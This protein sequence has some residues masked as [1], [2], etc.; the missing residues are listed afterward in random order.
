MLPAR[1]RR[2][3]DKAKVEVG[4]LIAKRWILALLRHRTFYSL[5][6]LNGAIV[7]LLER[8]NSRLLRKLKQSRRELFERFDL[9]NA[10][11]LP[12]KPY[13]YAEWKLATVN[14]D[15]HIEVDKH[16]YSVPYKLIHDKLDVRLTAHTVEAFQKSEAGGRPRAILRCLPSHHPQRAHAARPSELSGVDSFADHRLGQK[17]RPRYR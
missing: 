16:F 1:P 3:K 2:P 14:I 12:D 17:D 10:L 5:A 6:E 13:Q 7:Q 4:V 15:Y 9:P 8:L 11:S